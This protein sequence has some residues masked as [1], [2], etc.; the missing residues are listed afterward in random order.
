M[1]SESNVSQGDGIDRLQ[2]NLLYRALTSR[3]ERL[4]VF[5]T[6]GYEYRSGGVIS[7]ASI[8]RESLAL[9]HLHRSEV[10]LCIVPGEPLL[11]KY[12][13]FENRN[14]ILDLESVLGR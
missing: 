10:V 9:R 3:T 12:T 1:S 4:I 5:L 6:P 11:T 13:W 2:I 8:Y 14:Y 7:I